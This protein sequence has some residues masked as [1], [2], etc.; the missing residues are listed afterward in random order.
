MQDVYIFDGAWS[1]TDNLI[2]PRGNHRSV[3]KNGVI[4]HV[5]GDGNNSYSCKTF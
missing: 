2:I 1:K 5:G 3:A 4:Y